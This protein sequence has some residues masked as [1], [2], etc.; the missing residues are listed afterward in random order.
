M[1]SKIAASAVLCALVAGMLLAPSVP[2]L[3]A[4]DP[5]SCPPVA[6]IVN[7]GFET[8]AVAPGDFRLF[9]QGIVPGWET[10]DSLGN[11]ELWNAHRGITADTGVQ[12]AE[13]N[14]NSASRL[15]QDIPTVPGEELTWS[16]S[17]RAREGIDVMRVL[18]GPVGGPLVQNGPNLSS[19]VSRWDRFFGTYVVPAGQTSTRLA[20]EAVSSGSGNATYGNFLDSITFGTGSCVV[21]DKSVRN[22]TNTGGANRVGDTLEY[23]IA[24]SSQGGDPVDL[25]VISDALPAGI[26]YVPGSIVDASAAPRTPTDAAGDDFGEYRPATRTVTVRVGAGAGGTAGGRLLFGEVGVVTFR[27]VITSQAAA[28]DISNTATMDYADSLTGETHTSTSNTT[29]TAVAPASDLSVVKSQTGALVAGRPASYTV[30]VANNGPSAN[31]AVTLTD[32]LPALLT[33]GT[34]AVVGGAPCTIA[35]SEV[36]CVIGALAVGA[37]AT[38]EVRGSVPAGTPGG[39]IVTNTARASGDVED[40]APANDSSTVSGTVGTSAD[41]ALDKTFL[42]AAPVAGQVVTFRLAVSNAG[43]SD[44]TDIEIEDLLAPDVTFISADLPGGQCANASGRVTCTHPGLAFGAPPLVATV[45]VRLAP[46]TGAGSVAN[47]ATAHSAIDDANPLNNSDSVSFNSTSTADLGVSKTASTATAR[48]GQTV[49]YTVTVRNN[50]PSD[51]ANVLVTD[52]APAGMTFEGLEASDGGVCDRATGGCRW[53]SIPDGAAFTMTIHARVNADAGSGTVAN[54]VSAVSPTTDPDV[55]NNSASTSVAVELSADL[56]IEK[57][58]THAVAGRGMSYDLIVRNNGPTR[59]DGVVVSDI[60]PALAPG[61]TATTAGAG[62][63]TIAGE[64]DVRCTLD[65][66]RNGGTWI[67]TIA[68]ILPADY[69]NPT[70]TN[71]AAVQSATDDPTPDNDNDTLVTDVLRAAD[72][73]VVKTAQTPTGVVGEQAA[74]TI[75]VTN[76]GPSDTLGVTVAEAADAGLRIDSTTASQGA[77]DPA[78]QRWAVGALAVGQRAQLQVLATPLEPGLQSNT[79]TV[80]TVDSV[81][82]RP[83]SDS[84]T[85]TIEVAPRRSDLSVTKTLDA[86]AVAGATASYTITVSNPGPQPAVGV[87]L[88]DP[89][90]AA[91]ANAAVAPACPITSGTVECTIGDLAVGDIR[92]FTVRGDLPADLAVGAVLSNSASVRGINDDPDLANNSA[93]AG[94]QTV[95]SADLSLVKEI[96]SGPPVAGA[97]AEFRVTIRNAGPSVARDIVIQDPIDPSV[98]FVRAD[99]AG[100]TCSLANGAVTCSAPELAP[101]AETSVSIGVQLPASSAMLENTAAVGSSTPDPDSA[102]NAGSVQSAVGEEADLSVT[103]TAATATAAPGDNVEFDLVVTNDGP[104]DARNAAVSDSLPQGLTLVSVTADSGGVCSE[105]PLSCAWTSIAAGTSSSA[106]VVARVDDDASGALVNA[107]SVVSPTP[108]PDL[109]DNTGSATIAVVTEAD[110]GVAVSIDVAQAVPGAPVA[111]TIV[112]TNSG[113]HRAY[114]VRVSDIVNALLAAGLE[115]TSDMGGQCAVDPNRAVGCTLDFLDPGATWTITVRGTLDPA[116]A[117][118]TLSNSAAVTSLT[119]DPAPGDNNAS[120]AVPVQRLANLI[121][122]KSLLTSDPAV[123]ALA[124]FTITVTNDGLSNAPDVVVTDVPSDGMRLEDGLSPWGSFDAATGVWT[125]GALEV[126]ETAELAVS[127]MITRPGAH[128]NAAIATSAGVF[129]PAPADNAADVGLLVLGGSAPAGAELPATGLEAR[130]VLLAAATLVGTGLLLVMTGWRRSR[131][132]PAGGAPLDE[133]HGGLDSRA[134]SL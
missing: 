98:T 87:I 56:S 40:P 50:G 101:G 41:L 52:T 74:F 116:H 118:A 17:H 4:Q 8:P 117:G 67:I 120:A 89:L 54:T 37:R 93:T 25:A 92:Q 86:P 127:A 133:H 29:I 35:G 134:A 128:T 122:S 18:I 106:T 91:L 105:L 132:E 28:Q 6:S 107:S 46:G 21:V 57:T 27:A 55:S 23:R 102:N 99:S 80:S 60:V 44:A 90:P 5:A 123:G 36:S 103:K 94:V 47:T 121:V 33:G 42:P 108:D 51:A 104:S 129:D 38:V 10:N 12:F 115:A 49:D 131:R 62:S 24:T 85:A 31:S 3:A 97:Q 34:A 79:A 84:S 113:P 70:L 76:Y 88:T 7:G 58:S 83:A 20:F 119:A 66:L 14:A 73:S 9:P 110:L 11:I 30:V 100:A 45:A 1:T 71:V 26:E 112:V 19:G 82:P 2:A 77:F 22:L 53:P 65:T 48:P 75:E 43:P 68:G 96:T 63:C 15:F 109:A 95:T 59:A 111:Y 126:G 72:L 39:T 114:G 78:T 32:T 16:L 81:D 64:R 130:P 61:M 125:V 13:L 124:E 69:A